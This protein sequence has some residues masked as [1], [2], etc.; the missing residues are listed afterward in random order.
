MATSKIRTEIVGVTVELTRAEVYGIVNT[1]ER[2]G[3]LIDAL[4]ENA[5]VKLQWVK[6]LFAYD[7]QALKEAEELFN[8]S[9]SVAMM[10][11]TELAGPN[12]QVRP[13]VRKGED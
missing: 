9:R 6:S 2:L 7:K 12:S 8:V 1:A 3:E 11:D 5:P 10:I 13:L 4:K